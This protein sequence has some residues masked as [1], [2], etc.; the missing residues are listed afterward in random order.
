MSVI[1]FPSGVVRR[2]SAYRLVSDYVI[3]IVHNPQI[4]NVKGG[5]HTT[6]SECSVTHS[7]KSPLMRID[8]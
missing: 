6:D 2:L 8:D 7:M 4:I 3:L 5:E 1:H